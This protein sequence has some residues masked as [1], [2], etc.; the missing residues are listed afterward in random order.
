[1]YRKKIY[2]HE[3]DLHVPISQVGERERGSRPPPLKGE[4]LKK[5]YM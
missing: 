3:G 2:V 4:N 5:Q 1:M